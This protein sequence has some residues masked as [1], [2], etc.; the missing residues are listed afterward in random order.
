M[1]Q[2]IQKEFERAKIEKEEMDAERFKRVKDERDKKARQA[3]RT[4][5]AKQHQAVAIAKDAEDF[6]KAAERMREG[7][8]KNIQER[9]AEEEKHKA[10]KEKILASEDSDV[11]RNLK[12]AVLDQVE[13]PKRHF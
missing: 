4:S 10:H 7:T 1:A 9:R 12:E 6:R 13:I 11:L 8:K 3:K 2:Q 5:D